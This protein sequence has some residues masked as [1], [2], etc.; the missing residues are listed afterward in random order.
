MAATARSLLAVVDEG[1]AAVAVRL[2]SGA[3]TTDASACLRLRERL[4]P[5]VVG[6]GQ[7]H[8]VPVGSRFRIARDA[9][10]PAG[11]H[12]ELGNRTP[13]APGPLLGALDL[14]RPARQAARPRA[15]LLAIAPRGALRRRLVHRIVLVPAADA[16]LVCGGAGREN[17]RRLFLDGNVPDGRGWGGRG[18]E[19]VVHV[20]W[21]A[22]GCRAE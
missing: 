16:P 20:V 14:P 18:S 4:P 10:R 5:V 7:L 19:R 3:P 9:P 17:V 1:S 15:P 12:L 2:P 13:P 11:T 21:M 8:C 22:R 6:A